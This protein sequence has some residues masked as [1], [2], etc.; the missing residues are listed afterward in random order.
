M[1]MWSA[2]DKAPA[3]AHKLTLA[4]T[5]VILAVCKVTH[6]NQDPGLSPTWACFIQQNLQKC[7]EAKSHDQI[8]W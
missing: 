6:T 7:F 4:G 3:L 2:L 8:N 5:T 1:L